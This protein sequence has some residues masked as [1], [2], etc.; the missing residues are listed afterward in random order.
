MPL[1]VPEYFGAMSIGIDHIGPMVN[2][3]QK[4]PAASASATSWMLFVKRIG[5]RQ[6]QHNVIMTATRLRRA[7]LRL[8]VFCKSRSL[9]RPP[10]VSPTTPA[11]KTP[12]ENRAER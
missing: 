10:N 9:T 11:K 8:L 1:A 12:D 7:T 2:S 6:A 4:K 5:T 3:A